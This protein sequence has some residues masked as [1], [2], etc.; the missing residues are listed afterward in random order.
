MTW[1]VSFLHLA[2]VVNKGGCAISQQDLH[3]L[4]NTREAHG[5][6]V[7]WQ[8]EEMLEGRTLT[9]KSSALLLW[10]FHANA[11]WQHSA[12]NI[13]LCFDVS[14]KR[15]VSEGSSHL[16]APLFKM[17]TADFYIN[18]VAFLYQR[19]HCQNASIP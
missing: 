12:G 10:T 14:I 4:Q 5:L 11:I 9:L 6:H 1:I 16:D 3:V 13:F 7:C 2:G 18:S 8:A 15:F 17:I 19:Q